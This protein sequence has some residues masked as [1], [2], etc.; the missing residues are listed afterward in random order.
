MDVFKLPSFNSVA[1]YKS[2]L[3]S[4]FNSKNHTPSS[5]HKIQQQSQNIS[6]N[7]YIKTSPLSSQ[8]NKYN[9]VNQK[10]CKKKELTHW[11][12]A[13]DEDILKKNVIF[14]SNDEQAAK[15]YNTQNW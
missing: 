2:E 13:I 4:I 5:I 9:E 6:P 8:N 12:P 15:E 10:F 1:D 14:Q 3:H 7:S 11:S